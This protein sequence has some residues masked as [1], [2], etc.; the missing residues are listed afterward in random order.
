MS[1]EK[2]QQERLSRKKEYRKTQEARVLGF[3]RGSV[4]KY[5]HDINKQ[6][7]AMPGKPE[8]KYMVFLRCSN[9]TIYSYPIYGCSD[10]FTAA[11]RDAIEKHRNLIP[12]V[13]EGGIVQG[14]GDITYEPPDY[15]V[16]MMALGANIVVTNRLQ[17][18][19]AKES[20]LRGSIGQGGGND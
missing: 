15:L 1:R 10:G 13:I 20:D 3:G 2:K 19:V 5:V 8:E 16:Q 12:A 9:N 14:I 11:L 6:M 7:D 18:R 4:E 17:N